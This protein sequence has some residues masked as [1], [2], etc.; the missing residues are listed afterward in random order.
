MKEVK[1]KPCPFCGAKAS[2]D[3]DDV[4]FFFD[5]KKGCWLYPATAIYPGDKETVFRWNR[6]AKGEA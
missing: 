5:H 1:L 6:R 4:P 3:I 2:G